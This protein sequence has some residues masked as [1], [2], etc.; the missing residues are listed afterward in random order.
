MDRESRDIATD[1]SS[2]DAADIPPAPERRPYVTPRVITG[3]AFE[4]VQLVTDCPNFFSFSPCLNPPES[5]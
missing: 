4:K 3:Q 1:P 2:M 5:C